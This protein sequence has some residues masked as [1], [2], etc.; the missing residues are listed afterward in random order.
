MGSSKKSRKGSRGGLIRAIGLACAVGAMVGFGLIG[1]AP[2]GQAVAATVKEFLLDWATGR[3]PQAAALTT[4]GRQAAVAL[5]L[6]SAYS[7]LGAADIQLSMGPIVAHGTTA[8]ARFNA[9]VDLG[10]GGLPWQYQGEFQLRRIGSA[11]RV[12]WAPSVIAPG[13]HPG[14]RLAVLTTMPPRAQL[15]DSAGGSLIPPSPDYQVGVYPDQVTNPTTTATALGQVTG[16]SSE[17]LEIRS[18]ILAAP[19]RAF[20][21]LIRLEPADYQRM[22]PALDRIQGVVVHQVLEN[23]FGSTAP[24]VTGTVGTET[25][26]VL[27]TAGAPYRR[28]ITVGTSGLEQAFQATLAGTP[29]TEVVIESAQGN[30]LRVLRSW[31][32]TPG[33]PVRTTIDPAVQQAAQ[34][35]VSSSA[36]ASAIVAIRPGTGQ[37]LAVAQ[38]NVTGSPVIDPLAGQY[39]PGQAFTIV[40]A[41][42]LLAANVSVAQP[43]PCPAVN[44]VPGGQTF[45]NVP[46]PQAGLGPNPTFRS[47]FTHA[48]ATGFASLILNPS[49]R[50]LST[51]ARQF[52]IGT[53][54]TLPLPSF[55]GSISQ[56]SSATSPSAIAAEAIGTGNVQASPLA[57]ALAAGVVQSGA[58]HVP[59]LVNTPAA[60]TTAAQRPFSDQIIATLQQLMHA[61]ATT[62]AGHAAGSGSSAVFGQVG[63]APLAG[64]PHLYTVWFVGYSHNVAFAVLV[65]SPSTS[66]DPAARLAGQFAASLHG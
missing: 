14:D 2:P 33:H 39:L 53:Q 22:R 37:I 3:Y 28:G 55:A 26:R 10:R 32:G 12:D 11:W 43:Q 20:L 6:Q 13:L 19:S 62:G 25:A 50:N 30:P 48:C 24:A 8:T 9:A 41:A 58:W 7:Q 4:G 5:S 46:S 18:Q 36:T 51:T 63:T 54:W 17:A 40:S 44:Q 60:A 47:D 27:V 64:H 23:V 34:T 66:F 59:S 65:L 49:V 29:T 61:A 42:A 31:R 35:A 45:V 52:G 56:V 38:H 21:E 57:M 16:L 15:L 1:A